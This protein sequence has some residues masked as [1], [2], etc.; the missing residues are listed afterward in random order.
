M[1]PLF[2]LAYDG[3]FGLGFE[4]NKWLFAWQCR[5]GLSRCRV[6]PPAATAARNKVLSCS[7]P[8]QW[9]STL[10]LVMS[11]WMWSLASLAPLQEST[12]TAVPSSLGG[13]GVRQRRASSRVQRWLWAM[14]LAGEWIELKPPSAR[15]DDEV[16]S[17]VGLAQGASPADA[18][19]TIDLTRPWYRGSTAAH[20][21]ASMR[22]GSMVAMDLLVI[23]LFYR[24]FCAISLGQLFRYPVPSYLYLLVSLYVFLV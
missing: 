9:R 22:W 7:Y 14:R 2:F 19:S 8:P 21:K 15:V 11:A 6:W 18:S 12:W 24:G 13:S 1:K 4:G 5:L 16:R 3:I 17:M 23:F 10:V 20:F